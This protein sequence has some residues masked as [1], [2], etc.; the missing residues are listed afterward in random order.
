MIENMEMHGL[1]QTI[2]IDATCGKLR[3]A[4]IRISRISASIFSTPLQHILLNVRFE[5][6][7]YILTMIYVYTYHILKCQMRK[8]Y[9]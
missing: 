7:E 9:E 8:I 5:K 6:N 1:A 3:R 4:K 2:F